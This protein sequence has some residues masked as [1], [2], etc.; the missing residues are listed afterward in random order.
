MSYRSTVT[1]HIHEAMRIVMYTCQPLLM[2]S[3]G[4]DLNFHLECTN[5]NHST[6]IH[7]LTQ[8]DELCAVRRV[9]T[10][11]IGGRTSDGAKCTLPHHTSDIK[12]ASDTEQ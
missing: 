7:R 3:Y 12:G 9:G 4:Q 6:L 5:L 11:S 1:V 2:Y 10:N 8:H